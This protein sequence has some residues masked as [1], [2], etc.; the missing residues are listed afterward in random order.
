MLSE[1]PP[2]IDVS[3]IAKIVEWG[4]GYSPSRLVFSSI[5][6]YINAGILLP[7]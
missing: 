3:G 1:L 5:Q 7:G 2:Q 6:P 4:L